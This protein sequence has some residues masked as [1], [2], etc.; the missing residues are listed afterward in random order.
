MAAGLL[1]LAGCSGSLDSAEARLVHRVEPVYPAQAYA[2]GLEGYVLLEFTISEDGVPTE[3]KVVQSE[4][5][6]VFDAAAIAA[7]EQWRY[8]PRL[9]L[10]R[11]VPTEEAEAG[12]RFTIPTAQ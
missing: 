10:G 7:V 4:P 9:R 3:I 6:G 5:R 12:V 2:E 8:Q 1:V 11:A